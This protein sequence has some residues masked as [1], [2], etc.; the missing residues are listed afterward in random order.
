MAKKAV[1]R[2]IT[3]KQPTKKKGVRKHL[4]QNLTEQVQ[5]NIGQPIGSVPSVQNLR[6]TLT[7]SVGLHYLQA[8]V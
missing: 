8:W 7:P 1:K 4:K 5:Q 3:K 2:V 6:Q